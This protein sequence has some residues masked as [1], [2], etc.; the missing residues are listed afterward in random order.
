[1][2]FVVDT[3][4]RADPET[5]RDVYPVGE[6]PLS[7]RDKVAYDAFVLATRRAIQDG[8][9]EPARLGGCLV[10]QRVQQPFTFGLSR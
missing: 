5:I 4:G 10:R 3:T 7:E 9:Y 2:R 8:V 1:M 6:P